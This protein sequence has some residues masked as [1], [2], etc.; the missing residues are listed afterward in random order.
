MTR[1]Y[2]TQAEVDTYMAEYAAKMGRIRG[3]D[4]YMAKMSAGKA[5]SGP[6]DT[7]TEADEGPES[8]LQSKIKAHCKQQGWP[9]LSFPR[10]K[11]VRKFL[12]PGWPDD[13]IVMPN[14]Q[15]LWIEDKTKSGRASPKQVELHLIFKALGHEV[16][17]IRSFKAFLSIV[18]DKD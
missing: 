12:P 1:Y 15:T 9:C 11:A 17:V 10:T 16:H 3:R 7:D 5:V 6:G 13:C 14:S 18:Q 2:R 8:A 4:A